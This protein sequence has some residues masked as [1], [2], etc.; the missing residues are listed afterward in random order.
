MPKIIYDDVPEYGQFVEYVT[1]ADPIIKGNEKF[2]GVN[3]HRVPVGDLIGNSEKTNIKQLLDILSKDYEKI[4]SI[5]EISG[6][7]ESEANKVKDNLQD[8]FHSDVIEYAT[9]DLNPVSV[10]NKLKEVISYPEW[11]DQIFVEV[12]DIYMFE[13]NLYEAIQAHTTQSDW[14]PPTAKSLWKRFFEPS[15]DPWPWVQPAGAHDAYPLG[16]RVEYKGNIYE[17][18]IT[19]N[20][21]APDVT[22][23]KKLTAGES[24]DW[25]TGVSYSI[26]NEATYND[27]P[28]KC[29]Q[30]HTSQIGW[31]PP[32][33]PALWEAI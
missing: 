25:A 23:W 29:L 31:E 27:K 15:D 6:M 8:K 13:D 17:S 22:G 1:Q 24:Y 3:I 10:V 9:Q 11:E 7:D 19:A 16:A 18:T 14:A 20:V 33:T 5:R 21:W 4:S 32:N 30:A 12:G 2:F 28:Y 26:G